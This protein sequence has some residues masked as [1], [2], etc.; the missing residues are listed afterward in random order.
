MSIKLSRRDFIKLSAALGLTSLAFRP[1][2][3]FE[4]DETA[5]I[6]PACSKNR[7]CLHHPD[8][9]AQ[10]NSRAFATNWLTCIMRLIVH[11]A[12]I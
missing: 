7:Q 11:M 9:R 4:E 2:T 3:G 12:G 5:Q 10:S 8:I 6:W 1:F